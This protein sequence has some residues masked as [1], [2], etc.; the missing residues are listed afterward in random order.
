MCCR[1]SV[2]LHLTTCLGPFSQ[3]HPPSINQRVYAELLCRNGLT[4]APS[5]RPIPHPR[6]PLQVATSRR[7]PPRSPKYPLPTQRPRRRR[8][9]TTPLFQ[10]VR[11]LRG[12]ILLPLQSFCSSTHLEGGARLPSSARR[13]TG[14]RWSKRARRFSALGWSATDQQAL[15][16]VAVLKKT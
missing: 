13:T 1:R 7:P 6:A 12:F 11:S 3:R 14:R 2:H 10:R 8:T 5:V 9:S 15:Q 4:A 16:E